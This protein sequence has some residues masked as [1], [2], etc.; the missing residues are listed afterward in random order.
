[1]ISQKKKKKS[2][3]TTMDFYI[4]TNV[5]L[6]YGSSS[7]S[8]NTGAYTIEIIMTEPMWSGKQNKARTLEKRVNV[9]VTYKDGNISYVGVHE[10][11]KNTILYYII[12]I[13]HRII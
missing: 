9:Y 3:K 1:M 13:E 6:K 12:E 8:G 5:L 4:I 2:N 7:G 11:S 10:N